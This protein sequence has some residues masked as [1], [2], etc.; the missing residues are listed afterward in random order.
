MPAKIERVV[1]IKKAAILAF[2]LLFVLGT[3]LMP[4][5]VYQGWQEPIPF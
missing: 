3:M 2:V 5:Q 1:T 4:D